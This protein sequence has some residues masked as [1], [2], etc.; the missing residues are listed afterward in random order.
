MSESELSQKFIQKQKDL[1]GRDLDIEKIINPFKKG[2]PDIR[3]VY[4][5][6]PMFMESKLIND[7]SLINPK[8]FEEMQLRNLAIKAKSGSICLGLL[9]KYDS[10]VKYLFYNEILKIGFITK[11]QYIN[12]KIFNL[13]ELRKIWMERINA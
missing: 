9:M 5:G 13:D 10:P 3:A 4:K 1:Y 7:I 6:M 2:E 8:K 11:D 12:A